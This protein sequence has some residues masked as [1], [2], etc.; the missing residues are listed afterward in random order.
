MEIYKFTCETMENLYA[1]FEGEMRKKG[2]NKQKLVR[3]QN[4]EKLIRTF[5]R[6]KGGKKEGKV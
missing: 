6:E 5:R 4:N 3:L 2:G 1:R